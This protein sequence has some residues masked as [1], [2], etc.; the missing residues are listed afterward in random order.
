MTKPAISIVMPVYNV[1][2]YVTEAIESVLA[3]TFGNFELIIVDDGGS[4]SS[5]D[6]C[7]SYADPRIRIIAQP[8][9]GLAGARNSGISAARG[10]YIALLDADDSWDPEKLALHKIHLD[11]N[12]QVG[13]SYSG[14]RFMDSQGSLLR[15]AQRPKLE[16]ISAQDI[17]TR[18][19]VGNGSAPVIRKTALD[20]IAFD[21]PDEPGRACFFDE[22]FRQSEDIELW[23]RM[24]L[25]GGFRFEGIVGLLTNYRIVSGGLSANI[26]AQYDSWNR[27]MI[28]TMAYAP[29]FIARY[30]DEARSYQLRYLARRAV[31]MGDGAFALILLKEAFAISAKPLVREPVKSAFT[32]LAAAAARYL[33]TPFVNRLADG[34][35]G[36]RALR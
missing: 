10:E 20:S 33:P 34:W 11:N 31:Q 26:A 32:F 15:Q 13:V 27:V 14:S 19:P 21:H 23:I 16:N 25:T 1:E 35:T 12:P 3:Q 18:N 9:R 4:D 22:S 5:V 2:H 30:G 36:G 24:A 28:K 7:A 8:N 6:I 17:L 29:E